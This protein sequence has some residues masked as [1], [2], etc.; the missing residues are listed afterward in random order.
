MEI[1]NDVRK[2]LVDNSAPDTEKVIEN[3]RVAALAFCQANDKNGCYTDEY[4]LIECR[5][6]V[7]FEWAL[8]YFIYYVNSDIHNTLDEPMP[9]IDMAKELNLFEKSVI[10]LYKLSTKLDQA[11]YYPAMFQAYDIEGILLALK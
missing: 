11:M 5:E 1:V 7:N 10:A 8:S 4:S 6:I 3:M 9:A 2:V